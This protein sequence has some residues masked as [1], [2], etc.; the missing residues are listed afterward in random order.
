MAGTQAFCGPDQVALFVG[1]LTVPGCY[2]K[3]GSNYGL[4]SGPSAAGA[5]G[6][7]GFASGEPA[8]C[9]DGYDVDSAGDCSLL[10][11]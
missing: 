8:S 2:P 11:K 4:C 9:P 7:F 6:S 5:A 1:G 10:S 3:D